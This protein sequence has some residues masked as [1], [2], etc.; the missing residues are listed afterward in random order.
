MVTIYIRTY[1]VKG[2]NLSSRFS[3]ML[4]TKHAEERLVKR[5]SKKRKLER[6]YSELWSFLDRSS[7]I[8]V[9]EDV[10]ILTDG[11]KSLVCARLECEMLTFDEIKRRVENLKGTYRCVF[12]DKRL[13][14]ET[15]PAKFL[16]RIP[17]GV[18]CFYLNME[19]KSL[20]VG[21]GRPLLAITL[22]PAKRVER[23]KVRGAKEPLKRGSF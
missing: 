5:L 8:E 20:Y 3:F 11:R 9:N 18:Y 14:M 21:T 15:V 16:I 7:R 19:K 13:V 23:E 10:V 22:R 17:E 4:L 1:T 6:V 12:P 2:L